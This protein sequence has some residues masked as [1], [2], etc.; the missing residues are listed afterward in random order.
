MRNED[1][2]PKKLGRIVGYAIISMLALIVFMLLF[3]ATAAIGV[4]MIEFVEGL[5]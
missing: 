1:T 4:L 5:R 3:A 2:Y